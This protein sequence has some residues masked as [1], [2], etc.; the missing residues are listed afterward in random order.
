MVG[1][2]G[3]EKDLEFHSLHDFLG[4]SVLFLDA[5]CES[6]STRLVLRVAALDEALDTLAYVV[7]QTH[8][9]A[10]VCLQSQFNNLLHS[11]H[12]LI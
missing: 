11:I 12:Q 7:L 4:L 10:L 2:L 3:E 1:N 8:E 9:L 6:I 5:F